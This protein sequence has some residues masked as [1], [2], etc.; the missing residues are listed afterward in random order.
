MDEFQDKC[1]YGA[2]NEISRPGTRNVSL[3]NASGGKFIRPSDVRPILHLTATCS[4]PI[5]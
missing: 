1:A 3:H 2:G 5:D 4:A